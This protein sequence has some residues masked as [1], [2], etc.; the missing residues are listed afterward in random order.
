LVEVQHSN[1]QQFRAV[2]VDEAADTLHEEYETRTER[3]RKSL[4]SIDAVSTDAEADVTHEV[5]ALT[6]TTAITNRTQQLIDE[7]DGEI[8]F[9]LGDETIFTDRLVA[10]LRAAHQRGVNVV[11]GTTTEGIRDRVQDE[12]PEAEV[13]VSG[14]EWLSGS[15]R[16]DDTTEIGRLVLVD[17]NVILV[18]TFQEASTD[19]HTHEQAIFGRGFDNGLVT[20]A[21]RLMA[22]GLLPVED[23]GS[24]ER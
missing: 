14:L 10:R 19:G 1:P 9:V 13:F 18:S 4:A 3:L 15:M 16:P 7:A 22:T 23:P 21:R 6:G 24:S 2:S 8:V 5:W 17:E 12:L 20:I 11:F